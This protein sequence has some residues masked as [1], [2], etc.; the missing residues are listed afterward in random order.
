M[1]R[2]FYDPAN[3]DGFVD[4]GTDGT[5]GGAPQPDL[6]LY[7]NGTSLTNGG[8]ESPADGPTVFKTGTGSINYIATT[9]GPGSGGTN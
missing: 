5:G 8:T 7:H 6:F 9:D 2:Y 4:P 1:R 3:T